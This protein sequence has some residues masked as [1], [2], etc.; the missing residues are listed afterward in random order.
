MS[1]EHEEIS[2][3]ATAVVEPALRRWQKTHFQ[4]GQR[5]NARKA[6]ASLLSFVH[7]SLGQGNGMEI[8]DGGAC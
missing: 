1:L 3:S 2:V 5:R 7:L 8:S 4:E 6:L